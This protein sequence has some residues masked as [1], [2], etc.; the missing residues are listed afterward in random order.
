VRFA[1]RLWSLPIYRPLIRAQDP[2]S[3]AGWSFAPLAV[4]RA[5]ISW[6]YSTIAWT[7]STVTLLARLRGL[8]IS[9]PSLAAM[10]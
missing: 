3:L 9:R 10:W 4:T 7:Y 8:S 5:A 2:E 6:I 1:P